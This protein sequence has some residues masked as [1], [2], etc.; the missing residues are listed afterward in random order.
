MVIAVSDREFSVRQ[1]MAQI[2]PPLV[3]EEQLD[4]IHQICP[5]YFIHLRA[6]ILQ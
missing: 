5:K 6:H 1:L 4:L 3:V 2:R